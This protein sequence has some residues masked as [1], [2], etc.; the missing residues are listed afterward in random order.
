MI[1]QKLHTG[2]RCCLLSREPQILS[3]G[4][5]SWASPCTAYIGTC[6]ILGSGPGPTMENMRQYL[7]WWRHGLPAHHISLLLASDL[8]QPGVSI[9]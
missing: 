2:F 4:R 3:P 1:H 9:H 6:S 5:M 7:G 8:L